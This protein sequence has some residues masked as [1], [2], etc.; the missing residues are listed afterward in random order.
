MKSCKTHEESNKKIQKTLRFQSL[1]LVSGTPD[2]GKNKKK[3][4]D[5]PVFT[6]I[7]KYKYQSNQCHKY[8]K[9]IIIHNPFRHK[10]IFT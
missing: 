1:N 5:C 8:L 7:L 10:I 2:V 3:I 6:Y 4:L 9:N